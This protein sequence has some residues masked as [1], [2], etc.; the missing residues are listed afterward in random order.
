MK[1]FPRVCS[2][3]CKRLFITPCHHCGRRLP[4]HD[5]ADVVSIGLRLRSLWQGG[6]DGS[7][8]F[9]LSLDL[10]IWLQSWWCVWCGRWIQ[11]L[12]L[13]DVCLLVTGMLIRDRLNNHGIAFVDIG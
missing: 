8:F 9:G 7:V 2:I 4:R 1:Q 13:S 11:V 6:T 10:T 5:R 3:K 12:V